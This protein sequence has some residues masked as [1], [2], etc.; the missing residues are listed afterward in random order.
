LTVYGLGESDLGAAVRKVAAD[1]KVDVQDDPAPQ[2][3]VFVRSDQYNFVRRGV[4]AV[5]IDFGSRKGSA[6][7]A[8]EKAWLNTRYHAPSDDL[9]QPV[10]LAAAASY[11][12]FMSSLAVLVANAGAR[13]QW[14]AD[15]FF[16]R[17][18]S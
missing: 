18:V 5:M 17:F 13:P 15:S 4:P 9:G 10:D 8:T 3:N 12:R 1:M 16:K 2:R 11:N 6:E 7:E 14:K